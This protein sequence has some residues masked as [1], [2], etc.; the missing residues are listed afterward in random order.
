ME[1]KLPLAHRLIDYIYQSSGW[2]FTEDVC[3]ALSLKEEKDRD[4]VRVQLHKLADK[5]LLEKDKKVNAHWR[6]VEDDLFEMDL[7]NADSAKPLDIRYPFGIERVFPTLPRSILVCAGS[8]NSGKTAFMLNF[9]LL[10]QW[11]H[12]VVYFSSEMGA[13]R[14]KARLNK[15]PDFQREGLGFQAFERGDNFADAVGKFPN[16]LIVI[17][18]LEIYDNF[19]EIGSKIKAIF[20][21]LQGNG[22]CFIAVQK[23]PSR[24]NIKGQT[25]YVDLGRGG[26]FGLEKA[27][28]Y[29]VMDSAGKDGHSRLKIVKAKEWVH[30]NINPNNMEWGYKL[31]NGCQFVSIEEP[32]GLPALQPALK[33]TEPVEIIEVNPEEEPF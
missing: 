27:S 32:D 8:S 19:Y 15:H 21:K 29:L 3:R 26:N 10:N 17:D 6:K 33:Y 31:V 1:E 5:G 28:L 2:F 12:H 30:E 24:K 25:E 23:N 14:L 18:Y 4:N 20:D 7:N 9:C 13:S 16:S 11:K 22:V